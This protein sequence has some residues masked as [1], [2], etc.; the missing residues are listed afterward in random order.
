[1]H[2][3]SV[4]GKAVVSFAATNIDDILV[5]TLFFTQKNLS[6][7]RVVAGQYLGLAAVIAI[8]MS[9][10]FARM[11]IPAALIGFLGAVPIAIGLKK[12]VEWKENN[13][14]EEVQPPV[15]TSILTGAAVTFANGG[16]NI[17]V[18]VPLFARSDGPA[19][20][21]TLVIF[22]VMI[23]LWCLIGY[24]I[25]SHP[26][27]SRMV[28]RFGVILVPFVLIGLGFYIVINAH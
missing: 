2:W 3:S 12:I 7:W 19:L 1:M 10:F 26:I 28:D 24:Y 18:Y 5:L 4:L 15:V 21:T 8:S 11:I 17:A 13:D 25:G 20:I 16:D 27:V 6:R 23:A 22:T 14:G 9:G